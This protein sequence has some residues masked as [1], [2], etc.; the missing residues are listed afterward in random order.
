MIRTP[1]KPIN[2]QWPTHATLLLVA[3]PFAIVMF[4]NTLAALLW[5]A[6]AVVSVRREGRRR[7]KLTWPWYAAIPLTV[8]LPIIMA[9]HNVWYAAVW[10]VM[11]VIGARVTPDK[12]DRKAWADLL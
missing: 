6:A 11:A 12:S 7:R 10:V 3:V 5:L 2:V 8:S 9:F 4:T 1:P